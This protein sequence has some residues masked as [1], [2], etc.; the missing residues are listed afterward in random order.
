MYDAPELRGFNLNFKMMPRSKAEAN[1]INAICQTLKRAM[2]PS[3]G[4]Q[5]K[6]GGK[7]ERTGSLM[8]IPKIVSAKFMTGNKLNPFITQFKPC[9]ITNVNI[10]YTAD[11]TYATYA[12]GSP[13]ATMLQVQ[14]KELKL[15]FEDEIPLSDVPIASY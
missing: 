8:T 11:G 6:I 4:G 3:W 7:N 15:V 5:T 13:V 12:D 14:F 10:N 2:L 1:H 9:A